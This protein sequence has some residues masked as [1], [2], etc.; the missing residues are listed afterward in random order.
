MAFIHSI[1]AENVAGDLTF[2]TKAF[3]MQRVVTASVQAT[4]ADIGGSVSVGFK[5]QFSNAFPPNGDVPQNWTVPEASWV[6]SYSGGTGG[7]SGTLSSN[8]T[9]LLA[10]PATS[11][12]SRWIRVV[13]TPATG[14]GGTVKY[15][16]FARDNGK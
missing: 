10:V 7:A 14:T 2:K 1:M 15:E 11:L 12:L 3:D 13:Q 16:L 8:T 6:D 9:V 5:V 4:A